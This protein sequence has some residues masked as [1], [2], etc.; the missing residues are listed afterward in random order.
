MKFWK[1]NGLLDQASRQGAEGKGQAQHFPLSQDDVSDILEVLKTRVGI[2]GHGAAVDDDLKRF[3]ECVLR[4]GFF[5]GL[6][7]SGLSALEENE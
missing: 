6:E 7:S 1:L 4:F 2:E 3:G 5:I